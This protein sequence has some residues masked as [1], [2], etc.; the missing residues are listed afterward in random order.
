MP[1]TRKMPWS[2]PQ[3]GMNA[4]WHGRLLIKS[5]VCFLAHVFPKVWTSLTLN[6]DLL[7]VIFFYFLYHGNSPSFTTIWVC[8]TFFQAS[9]KAIKKWYANSWFTQIYL[10]KGLVKSMPEKSRLLKGGWWIR[11]RDDVLFWTL[12]LDPLQSCKPKKTSPPM[13]PP[14]K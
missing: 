6:L 12:A 14:K 7:K 2:W 10:Q 9:N 3:V 11:L 13:P 4:R 8:F 1:Q 5:K